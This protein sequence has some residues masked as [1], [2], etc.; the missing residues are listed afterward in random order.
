[1]EQNNQ[2]DEDFIKE[3]IVVS[4]EQKRRSLNYKIIRIAAIVIF[5][6][7]VL[8]TR[9]FTKIPLPVGKSLLVALAI[10]IVVIPI[11]ALVIAALFAVLP[12]GN[13]AYSK[14]FIRIALLLVLVIESL[15]FLLFLLL[16][17]FM[18]FITDKKI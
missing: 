6:N 15:T 14:K 12:S 10:S 9:F 3:L 8:L 18:A 5:A 2:I 4:N 16:S 13:L 1:M 17:I 7:V 11:A